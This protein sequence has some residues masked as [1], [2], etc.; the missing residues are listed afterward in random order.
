MLWLYSLLKP[1]ASTEKTESSRGERGQRSEPA[2]SRAHP[3]LNHSNRR[4]HEERKIMRN[5]FEIKGRQEAR[6]LQRNGRSDTSQASTVP[7]GH[8]TDVG[9][10]SLHRPLG[11]PS[12]RQSRS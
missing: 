8:G 7:S 9:N 3:G 12:E 1:E 11:W 5:M 4:N 6:W 10:V 2:W